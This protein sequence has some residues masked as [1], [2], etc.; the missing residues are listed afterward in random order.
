MQT[1]YAEDSSVDLTWYRYMYRYRYL[2]LVPVPT[3]L[4]NPYIM[5]V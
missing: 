4:A 5:I 1:T 3:E 2:V